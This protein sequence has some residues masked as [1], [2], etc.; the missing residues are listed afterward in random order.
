MGKSALIALVAIVA[1]VL[2]MLSGQ[3]GSNQTDNVE[4]KTTASME[5]KEK[6]IPKMK[7][8]TQ[9]LQANSIAREVVVQGQLEPAK[10]LRLR[11]E[12]SFLIKATESA[13][14]RYWQSYR[15]AIE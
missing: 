2:W 8:Q 9:V 5:Q 11:A 10:V 13:A 14:A 12:T 3:L 15:K 6:D 4:D 1:L 7:V